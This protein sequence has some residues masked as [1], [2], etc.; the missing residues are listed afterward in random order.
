[1]VVVV[2]VVVIMDATRP[3]ADAARRVVFMLARRSSTGG[4]RLKNP[5]SR[6]SRTSHRVN[7]SK[8]KFFPETPQK[9]DFTATRPTAV[10]MR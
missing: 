2:P 9:R 4:V 7:P 1:M 6:C 10:E 8:N 3:V 5:A